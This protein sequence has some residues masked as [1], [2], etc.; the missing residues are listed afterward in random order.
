M[1]G[2]MGAV[3]PI[4]DVPSWWTVPTAV[5]GV[6]I[7][8]LLLVLHVVIVRLVVRPMNGSDRVVVRRDTPVRRPPESAPRLPA[9]RRLPLRPGRRTHDVAHHSGSA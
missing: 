8:G 9:D 4:W 3:G 2:P 1:F 6:V 5:L 7:L